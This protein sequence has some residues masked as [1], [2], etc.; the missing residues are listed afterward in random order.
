MRIYVATIETSHH[1]TE[2]VKR[3][4]ASSRQAAE[5]RMG[6]GPRSPSYHTR[7]VMTARQAVKAGAYDPKGL[8]GA[9][10]ISN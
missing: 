10:T 3:C 5:N 4:A 2:V 6:C 1:H 7:V 9:K 8:L